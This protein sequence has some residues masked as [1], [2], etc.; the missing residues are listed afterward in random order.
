M[1]RKC[2][3]SGDVSSRISD[4]IAIIILLGFMALQFSCKKEENNLG[5]V[6]NLSPTMTATLDNGVLTIS[7]NKD[8]EAMPDYDMDAPPWEDEKNNIFS[9][10]IE[11]SVISV[12]NSAFRECNLTS[13]SLSGSVIS[14]GDWAFTR[15]F[16]L[17]SISIPNS[18]T[19]IGE[20]TFLGC[21]FTSITIPGSM[22]SIGFRA[23]SSCNDLQVINVDAG[24]PAYSSE[25]GV[26]YNKNMTTLILYP[27]MKSNSTFSIPNSVITVG[28]WAFSVSNWDSRLS[29]ITIPNSVTTIG[30]FAFSY[31]DLL[32]SLTI[33]AS[34]KTIG[35]SAFYFCNELQDVSVGWTD[36]LPVPDIFPSLNLS[37]M[38]LY[39]PTGTKA[40]YAAADVWMDFG[41]IIEK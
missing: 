18:V 33:P 34:V 30:E 31:C 11:K 25:A 23:F 13:V 15:C 6:W 26:L 4:R 21:G 7:T 36:P 40:R 5:I 22:T 2:F 28:D 17:A 27:Q 3:K 8:A 24:N 29:S 16:S 37:S 38:K 35:T 41:T 32:S 9:V 20:Y 14:I 12:G 10:V 1:K 39:V 19:S